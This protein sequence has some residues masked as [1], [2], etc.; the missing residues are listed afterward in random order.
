MKRQPLPPA[1]NPQRCLPPANRPGNPLARP[2]WICVLL[3]AIT[4]A[5][6]W[7]AVGFDFVNYDDPEFITLNPHVPGGLTW[8]NIRWA[9]G[10]GLGGSWM[11]LTWLSYMLDVE[12]FGPTAAGMHLTN[13]VLHAANTVLTFLLFR[14]LTGMHWAS[15]VLAG[16]FGLHPLHVESVAWVAERK[17]LL[18]TLFWSLAIWMYADFAQK[19]AAGLRRWLNEYTLALI[20]SAL[21]LMCKPMVVTLPFALLLLD[22]WPLRR[23]TWDNLFTGPTALTGL[24]LEKIPFFLLAAATSA[25]TFFVQGPAVAPLADLPVSARISNAL[26]GYVRY[27]GK[28]FWP[29]NLANPYPMIWHWPGDEVFAAGALLAGLSVL[30]VLTARKWPHGL[31]GWLWFL[32]TLLPVIGLVQ[33]GLQSMAD[34]YTYVPLLG[35]FWIV[36]WGVA[37][38]SA[39]WRASG[40]AVACAAVLMLGICAMRTRTQLNYWRDGEALFRHTIALTKDNF[41]ALDGLGWALYDKGKLDE[42]VFYFLKSLEAR[43]GYASALDGLKTALTRLDTGNAIS[44]RVPEPAT[45]IAADCAKG[46]NTL[47]LSLAANGKMDAA[48]THFRKALFYEPDYLNAR[49]NLADAL[50]LQG[51]LDEAIGQSEQVLQ[52]SPHYPIANHILGLALLKQGRWSEAAAHLREAVQY[53]PDFA[54]AHYYLGLALAGLGQRDEAIAQLKESLRLNPK[55]PGALEK[56]NQLENAAQ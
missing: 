6:Y 7:P 13:I 24:M 56:L 38:V 20:F 15:A 22:G 37:G 45:R 51:R 55:E 43:P 16:M 54:D 48:I 47:G 30:A 52:R 34:R 41:V 4:A 26:V 33:V 17:D 53:K 39:R 29:V 46:H 11:P 50:L 8:E 27:L 10:T 25:L 42:A 3:A 21:G 32:V 19:P 18:S 14:R 28:T 44:H 36:I 31:A 35:V 2:V 9:F 1:Q 5:V 12:W 23:F 49:C 40:G